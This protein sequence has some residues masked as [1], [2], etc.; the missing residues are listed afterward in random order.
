MLGASIRRQVPY[1]ENGGN[2]TTKEGF[3]PEEIVELEVMRPLLG[4]LP[5]SVVKFPLLALT[6]RP[7]GL[8]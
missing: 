8:P 5:A 3:P 6:P 4:L 1:L 2:S 7:P